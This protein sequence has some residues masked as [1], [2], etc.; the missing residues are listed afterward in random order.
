MAIKFI[1]QWKFRLSGRSVPVMKV[2]DIT[3]DGQIKTLQAVG[4]CKD[5]PNSIVN[6]W[7]EKG[8]EKQ[9][10][11]EMIT[12]IDDK[13]IKSMVW[14]VSAKGVTCKLFTVPYAGP[15]L[16]DVIGRLAT[17]DDIA[18]AISLGKSMRNLFIGG[19]FSAPVWWIVFQVL[20]TMA[21]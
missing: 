9:P 7:D 17:M 1:E 8:W 10:G 21:K 6:T 11:T 16:E 14:I 3:A 18:D 19:L 20:G 5:R 4:E 12:L 15:M 2:D 13:G